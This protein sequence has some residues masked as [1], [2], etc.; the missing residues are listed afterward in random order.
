MVSEGVGMTHPL[1]YSIVTSFQFTRP[2]TN[3]SYTRGCV[4]INCLFFVVKLG[5]QWAVELK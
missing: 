1:A 4:C 2:T 5:V 3:C